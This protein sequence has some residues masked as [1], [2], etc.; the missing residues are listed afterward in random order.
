MVQ[1]HTVL[2]WGRPD[3]KLTTDGAQNCIRSLFATMNSS[4]ISDF[5]VLYKGNYVDVDRISIDS[6]LSDGINKENENIFPSL[7][8]RINFRLLLWD[9]PSY[10]S[11]LIGATENNVTNVFRLPIPYTL[12]FSNA[13]VRVGLSSLFSAV[14]KVYNWYWGAITSNTI[15]KQFN[16]FFL[17]G[18][19]KTVFL[20]NYWEDEILEAIDANKLE[21]LDNK[22]GLKFNN[23]I[24][25]MDYDSYSLENIIE[26]NRCIF[27]E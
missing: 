14:S 18:M 13:E 11:V 12:D 4:F 15:I 6:L 10:G 9:T 5:K 24:V 19:P 26:I 20:L 22:Y 23:N 7:G 8:F 25:S 3:S 27:G 16:P 2:F 1:Q 17:D 21:R